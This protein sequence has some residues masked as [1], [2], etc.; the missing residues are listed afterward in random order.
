MTLT[1]STSA[2]SATR[3]RPDFL[4][5]QFL[6]VGRLVERRRPHLTIAAFARALEVR[7]EIRLRIIGEGPL[8]SV[9]RDLADMLEIGHAVQFLGAQPHVSPCAE[10]AGIPGARATFD[11]GR[12]WR[13]RG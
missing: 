13:S 12:R 11:Y 6:A 8:L 7:P 2:N 9:C 3:P 5:P 1:A 4:P 10:Y